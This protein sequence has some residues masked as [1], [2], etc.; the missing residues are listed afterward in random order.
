MVVLF[1]CLPEAL[2][3]LSREVKNPEKLAKWPTHSGTIVCNSEPWVVGLNW[4]GD[5][6]CSNLCLETPE[7]HSDWHKQN[8]IY[9]KDTRVLQNGQEAGETFSKQIETRYSGVW[10][11][12]VG[13]TGTILE[14]K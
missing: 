11:Q 14:Q 6:S 7:P 13:V 2:G 9:Y 10:G 4:L 12:E 5:V 1:Y 8:E 3:D